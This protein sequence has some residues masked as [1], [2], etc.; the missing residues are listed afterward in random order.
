MAVYA[1]M[2]LCPFVLSTG[3]ISLLIGII[4]LIILLPK[5]SDMQGLQQLMPDGHPRAYLT[6]SKKITDSLPMRSI[7]L[8]KYQ[9]ASPKLEKLRHAPKLHDHPAHED[10]T[11]DDMTSPTPR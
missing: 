11:T 4:N 7:L 6:R 2:A 3:T 5:A 8:A 10:I 9:A 1:K